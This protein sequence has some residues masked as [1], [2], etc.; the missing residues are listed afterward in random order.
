MS[1]Q[2]V[3]MSELT[4]AMS[5]MTINGNPHESCGQSVKQ[6]VKQSVKQMLTAASAARSCL[7][8]NQRRPHGFI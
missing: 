6:G 2:T 8:F 5:K 4:S 1:E 3:T 7:G